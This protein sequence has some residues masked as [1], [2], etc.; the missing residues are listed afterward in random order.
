ML[1]SIILITL[2]KSIKLAV[3][4]NVN[5]AAF[6]PNFGQSNASIAAIRDHMIKAKQEIPLHDLEYFDY[7]TSPRESETIT[8][9]F[10]T[11]GTLLAGIRLY[12][13][14]MLP[15]FTKNDNCSH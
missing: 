9:R 5:P 10:G 4:L 15:E 1:S 12:D 13:N 7:N 8:V 3:A 2:A 6:F 14:S 11:R